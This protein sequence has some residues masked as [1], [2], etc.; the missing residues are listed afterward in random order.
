MYDPMMEDEDMTM[1]DDEQADPSTAVYSKLRQ[2]MDPAESENLLNPPADFGDLGSYP[3]GAGDDAHPPASA[4]SPASSLSES[5]QALGPDFR[6][7]MDPEMV[8]QDLRE[9]LRSNQ[10]KRK[11]L[12]D[13]FIEENLAMNRG[14]L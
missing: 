9:L 11:E 2:I 13:R 8:R 10:S 4:L 5:P 14:N 1:L 12:Q 3:E 7:S 6:Q